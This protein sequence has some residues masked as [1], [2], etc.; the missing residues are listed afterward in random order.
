MRPTPTQGPIIS[1]TY[2]PIGSN[3]RLPVSAKTIELRVAARR[4]EMKATSI[5]YTKPLK[6]RIELES[7]GR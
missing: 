4:T 1:S 3:L 2:M 6:I 7:N 5:V